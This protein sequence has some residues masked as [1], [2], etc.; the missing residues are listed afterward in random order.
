[1]K[2]SNCSSNQSFPLNTSKLSQ[3]H[4]IIYV[5]Q[6]LIF[7]DKESLICV[8]EKD[9][10]L[11]PRPMITEILDQQSAEIAKQFFSKEVEDI[12]KS[13]GDIIEAHF[14]KLIHEWYEAC[15]ERGIFPEK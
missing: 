13:N 2:T 12:M 9:K 10:D 15:D 14:L 6:F 11:L 7:F 5:N 1:M 4:W 3:E 8:S